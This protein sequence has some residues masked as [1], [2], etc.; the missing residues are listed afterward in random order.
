MIA[1]TFEKWTKSC[2][3]SKLS[4]NFTDELR[5]M[6]LVLSSKHHIF[7]IDYIFETYQLIKDNEILLPYVK[8]LLNT[9]TFKEFKDKAILIST[10]HMHDFFETE[11]VFDMLLLDKF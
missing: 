4:Y 6:A 5:I 2:E 8:H 3:K 7:M 10:L 1:K 11:E 9:E